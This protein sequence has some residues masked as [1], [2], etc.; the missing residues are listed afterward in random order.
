M[1]LFYWGGGHGRNLYTVLGHQL[2]LSYPGALDITDF[3]KIT[4]KIVLNHI[5]FNTIHN[6]GGEGKKT[7]YK[8][9][10]TVIIFA[11]ICNLLI[12]RLFLQ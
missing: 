4:L 10:K 7:L 12:H 6:T 3:I 5:Q 8:Y 1:H 2:I 9:Q 11:Q